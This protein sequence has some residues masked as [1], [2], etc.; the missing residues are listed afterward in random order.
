[1]VVLHASSLAE[2]SGLLSANTYVV[3]DFYADWCGPCH[4]IKP[5]YESL[6]NN[7]GR[8]GSLAF[9]KVNVDATQD[10][11]RRYGVTAMPTFMFFEKGQPYNGGRSV[12]RG[13]DPR[14]LQATVQELSGLARMKETE[15]A[16]AAAKTAEANKKTEAADVKEAK[17]DDGSTVSGGYTLGVNTGLRSDWKM[18]LRG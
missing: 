8:P 12:A 11:A 7:H 9:V 1:M 17:P 3:V 15:A 5:I 10:V 2:F 16:E 13:A 6:S 14:T 4:A 18:S